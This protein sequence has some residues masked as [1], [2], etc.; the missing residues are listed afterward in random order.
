MCAQ[1]LVCVH[2]HIYTHKTLSFHRVLRWERCQ[3]NTSFQFQI[4]GL[5][6]TFQHKTSYRLTLSFSLSLSPSLTLSPLA[7]YAAC[8]HAPRLHPVHNFNLY[9]LYHFFFPFHFCICTSSS[10]DFLS[11]LISTRKWL[12]QLILGR[13]LFPSAF[14]SLSFLWNDT[15]HHYGTLTHLLSKKCDSIP[16]CC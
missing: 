11:L 10:D 4:Q 1:V 12:V 9:F 16:L 6:L 3:T 14:L 13:F 2:T 5:T 7:C 15:F 8:Q